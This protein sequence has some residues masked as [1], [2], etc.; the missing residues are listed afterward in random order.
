M[1]RATPGIL[2]RLHVV[3]ARASARWLADRRP[4]SRAAVVRS[5]ALHAFA[6][7]AAILAVR[8][9]ALPVL[10]AHA[11]A[12][13]PVDGKDGARFGLVEGV[14]REIFREVAAAEPA[15]RSRAAQTFPGAAWSTEDHRAALERDMIRAIA[16]RRQLSLSQVYLV[17]DEGIRG[18]WPGPDG[19]P[20]SAQ[21]APL[22][23]RKR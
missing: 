16:Q 8:S 17:L 5:V 1:G 18:H 12:D 13:L 6:T 7:L 20:L 10:H 4:S 19:N 2:R 11:P 9:V 3:L 21:S 22:A 14:R 23:P 15:S